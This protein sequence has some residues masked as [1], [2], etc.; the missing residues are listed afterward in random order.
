MTLRSMSIETSRVFELDVPEIK[1]LVVAHSAP[2]NSICKTHVAS[3][4]V[5]N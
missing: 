3:I 1:V 5:L 2:A 4:K